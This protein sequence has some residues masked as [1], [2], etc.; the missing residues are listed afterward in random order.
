MGEE[1]SCAVEPEAWQTV[2]YLVVPW[3]EVLEATKAGV[4]QAGQDGEQNNQEGEESG[5]GRQTWEH[6]HS[7][8]GGW[9]FLSCL[10]W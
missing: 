3:A 4:Q 6:M 5:R 2:W 10:L 9:C 7:F 8:E 1:E